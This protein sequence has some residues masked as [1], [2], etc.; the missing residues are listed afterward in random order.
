[1]RHLGLFVSSVLFFLL[2]IQLLLANPSK[3]KSGLAKNDRHKVLFA[4]KIRSISTSCKNNY[5][6]ISTNLGYRVYLLDG[7][8][9]DGS[10]FLGVDWVRTNYLKGA[11]D[12]NEFSLAM[13]GVNFNGGFSKAFDKKWLATLSL[14]YQLEEIFYRSVGGSFGIEYQINKIFSIA[15]EVGYRNFSTAADYI[16]TSEMSFGISF[17]VRF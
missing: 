12:F 2:S 1:M 14:S 4:T 15:P 17:G 10:F 13:Y 11:L 7:L 5:Y 16:K 8:F 3:P 6:G 9:P